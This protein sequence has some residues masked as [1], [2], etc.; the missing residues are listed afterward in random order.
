VDAERLFSNVMEEYVFKC[1]D[2]R[3]FKNMQELYDGFAFRSSGTS[4]Y[5]SNVEKS[6]C[7]NRAR[8]VIHDG[9]LARDLAKSQNANQADKRV[10][11]RIALLDLL[12]EGVT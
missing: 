6:D 9:K 3:A 11:D 5:H 2:G 10:T 4:A 12:R 7:S 1:N 8:D